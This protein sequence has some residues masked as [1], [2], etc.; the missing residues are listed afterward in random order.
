MKTEIQ[1]VSNV[2]KFT[3]ELVAMNKWCLIL[4]LLMIP[5]TDPAQTVM[6]SKQEWMVYQKNLQVKKDSLQREIDRLA[7]H[8]EMQ[9]KKR[10]QNNA[11]LS[12]QKAEIQSL[13]H[14]AAGMKK[15]E[16]TPGDS[17]ASTLCKRRDN[18][19]DLI[20]KVK[21]RRGFA[22]NC[23]IWYANNKLYYPYDAS[24]E[25][26][27][28]CLDSIRHN[29]YPQLKG[30]LQDYGAFTHE[31]LRVFRAA[32]ADDASKV[33]PVSGFSLYDV[34]RLRNQY[35]EKW[36]PKIKQ[37]AYCR[38]YYH[39]NNSIHYLEVLIDQVYLKRLARYAQMKSVVDFGDVLL[40]PQ[41]FNVQ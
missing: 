17:S 35:V 1:L 21:R 22:D 32:Q 12:E 27:A 4:W 36:R 9:K 5:I 41:V 7:Q 37:V 11:I 31:I 23:V 28:L 16:K 2:D 24:V 39:T 29:P 34:K 33:V 15:T 6:F 19:K 30:I 40:F 10:I 8:N 25:E 18:L 26:A 3:R 38:R 14:Q 13:Q 20:L